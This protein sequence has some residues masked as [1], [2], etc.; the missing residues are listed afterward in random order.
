M[1]DKPIALEDRER[2]GA[3]L[4]SPSA[5]RNKGV[6]SAWLSDALPPDA[7]V[8]EVG[9]G[10]GEHGAALGA[11][12]PDI[13]WQYSDPDEMSRASQ[14]AWARDGWPEPL[15]LDLMRPDWAAGLP[16]FDALFSAN[17]IHIAPIEATKGLA[18]GA[19]A[20]SDMVVLYGP[21]LFG[22]NSAPSNL[23]FDASLK[24]R[25]PRWGVREFEFVKHIF[26]VEGFTRVERFDMPRNNCVVRLSRP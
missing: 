8:L 11:R 17:M 10:T 6:V 19:A 23:E 12:R 14:A 26:E 20:L 1:T 5:E 3:R 9:S 15:A 24:R 13:V 22:E 16:R 7:R 25:D 21:F 4:Y 2:D 18:A